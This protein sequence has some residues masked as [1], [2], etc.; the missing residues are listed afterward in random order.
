MGGLEIIIGLAVAIVSIITISKF[1]WSIISGWEE[2]RLGDALYK[3]RLAV[4]LAQLEPNKGESLI[5][6][7]EKIESSIEE[8]KNTLITRA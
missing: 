2:R 8:I 5:D 6:R 1:I 7:V 3:K 4:A